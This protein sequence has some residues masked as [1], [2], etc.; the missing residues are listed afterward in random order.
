MCNNFIY[1][2]FCYASLGGP[3]VN[4]EAL[5]GI[6]SLAFN[7]LVSSSLHKVGGQR[8][9]VPWTLTFNSAPKA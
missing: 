4:L 6:L 2:L 9:A 1:T 8:P 5:L 7:S 3:D